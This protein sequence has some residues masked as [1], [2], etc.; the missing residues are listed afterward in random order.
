MSEKTTVSISHRFNVPAYKDDYTPADLQIIKSMVKEAIDLIGGIRTFVKPGDV[1][2][3]KPNGVAAEPP[4]SGVVT[5]PR[6]IEALIEIIYEEAEAKRVKIVERT[7]VSPWS[8][9]FTYAK[10]FD[11]AKRTG[12]ETINLDEE[13]HVLTEIPGAKTLKK[14][15]VPKSYI[16]CDVLINVPKMKT[17]VTCVA[18]LGLKN[19]LGM[20]PFTDLI[21]YHKDDLHQMIVDVYSYLRPKLTIVDGII[22]MQAQG[23]MFGEPVNDMNVLVAGADGV[24]VDAVASE[25]MGIRSMELWS[26]RLAS[27][28]GL[29]TGNLSAITVKGKTIEEVKRRFL[30]AFPDI[31]GYYRWDGLTYPV[32]AYV[33]GA[34]RGGCHCFAREGLD[35]VTMAAKALDVPL[36]ERKKAVIIMG[37]GAKVP[38]KLPEDAVVFVL[39]DCAKE[40]ADKGL[41]CGGCP[42]DVGTFYSEL[43]PKLLGGP[44]A[45]P[46]FRR[47]KI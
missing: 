32:E 14:V 2:L 17:H 9:I 42:C 37:Y 38:D 7:G 5:D 16:D 11:V 6:V 43:G 10:W 20:L 21:S 3:L 36:S 27:I 44:I 30:P 28:Q 40:H 8:D 23:P 47:E 18:T 46:V 22:A 33:G 41:F 12:A 31:I 35:F 39:G 1:V 25:V 26:T 29:G 13:E 45:H 34:C 4:W 15:R 19:L 24:A